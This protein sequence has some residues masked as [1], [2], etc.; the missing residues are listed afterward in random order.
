MN[1]M[2]HN[3]VHSGLADYKLGILSLLDTIMGRGK[4]IL[5]GGWATVT[6][7]GL[8]IISSRSWWQEHHVHNLENRG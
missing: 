4:Y 2:K 7:M 6:I 3:L 1:L 5:I 8:K